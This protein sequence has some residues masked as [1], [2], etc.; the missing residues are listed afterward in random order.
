MR[1]FQRILLE[2][3]DI[4]RRHQP[5]DEL[6]PPRSL[7]SLNVFGRRMTYLAAGLENGNSRPPIVFIHGFGGFFMDWPRIMAPLSRYT[8][9]YALDLPGWGFSERN[10]NARAI[11]DDATAVDEFMRILDLKDAIICG[12]SYGAGVAWALAAENPSKLRQLVLLNPMPPHP[13]RYM[14]SPIY[15]GIF[16]LNS[17]ERV[18]EWGHRLLTKSQYKVICRENLLN[19]RL[20]DSFYLDLA[21]LIIKQPKIRSLLRGHARGARD[22]DWNAWERR[23]EEIRVPVSILQGRQ[24]RIFSLE[25]AGFLHRLMPNSQLVE[26]EKCGHAIVFDQHRRVSEHLIKLLNVEKADVVSA[27]N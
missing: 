6:E 25:G 8:R 9:V 16:F 11:E 3:K 14:T 23:L 1:G 19:H 7:L 4:V 10:P 21:Y 13:I 12:L 18:G 15:R 24:D 26:V 17:F 5:G 20:L 22:T 27:L 2:L